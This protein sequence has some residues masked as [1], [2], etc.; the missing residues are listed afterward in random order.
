MLAVINQPC[1]IRA[2][3]RVADGAKAAGFAKTTFEREKRL[4]EQKI[5]AEQDYLQAGQALNEA[6][7]AVANAQQKLS[8]VGLAPGSSG[9]LNRFRAACALRW[10]GD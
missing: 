3:Q 7:V 5:S 2:A 6:Q 8:A 9:G 1:R 4:W 10:R